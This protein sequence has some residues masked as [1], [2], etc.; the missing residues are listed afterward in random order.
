MAGD[1]LYFEEVKE[2]QEPL[3][4]VRTTDMMHF[5]RFAAVNDEFVS[6]HMDDEVARQRGE[7]AV[8]GMGNLRF[9]YLHNMLR[10]WIGDTGRIRRVSCEY[11]GINRKGDTLTCRGRVVRKYVQGE[12]RL[13]DLEVWVERQN[14]EK[15]SVGQAIVAL[16]SR[17]A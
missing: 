1:R 4:F 8:V 6:F 11:R 10:G 5:N 13:V 3:P 16:P 17:E 9:S 12:E 2:G 7:T 15:I 14:G